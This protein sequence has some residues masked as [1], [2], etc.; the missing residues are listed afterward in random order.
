MKELVTNPTIDRSANETK[1]KATKGQ[2]RQNSN[3]YERASDKRANRKRRNEKNL[4]NKGWGSCIV[5]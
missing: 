5:F 4:Q 1:E 3:C 2:M